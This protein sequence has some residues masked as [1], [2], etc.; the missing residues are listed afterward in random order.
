MALARAFWTLSPVKIAICSYAKTKTEMTEVFRRMALE[1]IV[2]MVMRTF[3]EK[4]DGAKDDDAAKKK[5]DDDAPQS[6]T[7]H[8]SSLQTEM[9]GEEYEEFD[10]YLEM[11]IS[12]GYI[13]LFASAYPLAAF[14]S[15]FANFVEMR[16]D[17]LKLTKV[18]Y[19]PRSIPT[20]SIGMWKFLLKAIIWLS[21]LTNCVFFA[22]TSKQ[23]MQWAPEFY[24]HD[25]EADIHRL[26]PGKGKY[27][28]KVSLE[29][30]RLK[31][32]IK[33]IRLGY[34]EK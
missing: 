18:H 7:I 24:Y 4:K 23:L 16:T 13:T 21:A 8:A 15:V 33:N 25:E 5:K 30:K 17:M 31:N 12:V 6:D 10:D 2:P 19:R 32:M 22:F 14:I 34:R 20:D 9:G 27:R 28:M 26:S 3:S 1:F 29:D 11:V